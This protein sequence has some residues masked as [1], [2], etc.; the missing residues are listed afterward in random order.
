MKIIKVD[1][2]ELDNFVNRVSKYASKN[3]PKE[4][5]KFMKKEGQKLRRR[6]KYRLN[7]NVKTKTGNLQEGLKTSNA[8]LWDYGTTTSVKVYFSRKTAPH[9]HLIEEGHKVKNKKDGPVLGFA[10]GY[11]I[12]SQSNKKFERTLYNDCV[13]FSKNILKEFE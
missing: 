5:K 1:F 13:V 7:K 3:Y 10:K 12:L 2:K 11:S 4:T 8:Y 6:A 9:G